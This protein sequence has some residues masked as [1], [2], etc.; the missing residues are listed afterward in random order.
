MKGE[1]QN[2]VARV[3]RAI[4][5]LLLVVTVVPACKQP[6]EERV[7]TQAPAEKRGLAA[8]KRAGCGACHEIDGIEWP[9]GRAGPSL[10]G[11]DDRTPIAG[12]LPNTP[13]NLAAFIRN[14]SAVVP[15]S[16]MPPMPVTEREA[17]DIA[18]YL[19]SRPDD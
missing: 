7:T 3:T 5:L 12:V 9:R 15:G 4:A 10:M 1:F 17:R 6:P 14:A 16:T 11:F 18:A 2:N 19:Y 8:I 13:A